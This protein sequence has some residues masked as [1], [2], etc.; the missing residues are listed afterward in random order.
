LIIRKFVALE[1]NFTKQHN[2]LILKYL[3]KLY[4]L[5]SDMWSSCVNATNRT[6]QCH[7]EHTAGVL[8]ITNTVPANVNRNYENLLWTWLDVI[9]H[10]FP[11]I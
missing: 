1:G 4:Y 10:I 11:R 3:V 7:P 8:L 9:L 5:L 2:K 6:V